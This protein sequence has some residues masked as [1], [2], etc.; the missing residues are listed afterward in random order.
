MGL[1]YRYPPML[2]TLI[3]TAICFIF[4][5]YIILSG[6][7]AIY[8]HTHLDEGGINYV[9]RKPDEYEFQITGK[10]KELDRSI[11]GNYVGT[12]RKYNLYSRNTENQPNR[13]ITNL[14]MATVTE[15][16]PSW[17]LRGM[18]PQ[19]KISGPS[20]SKRR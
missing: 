19:H 7:V 2:Q 8:I 10:P 15:H 5:F 9:E 20:C 1:G 14:K 3:L 11:F 4:S 16:S 6:S 13:E 17:T 18:K 12:I